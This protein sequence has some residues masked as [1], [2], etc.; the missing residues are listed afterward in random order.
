[1]LKVNP[2]QG[3]ELIGFN[4]MMGMT[5]S[6]NSAGTSQAMSS[7]INVWMELMNNKELL[8]KQ[9]DIYGK[10]PT[11]YNQAVIIVDKNGEISDYALYTLGIKDP[12]EL[13]GLMKDLATGGKI[14]S[15]EQEKYTYDYLMSL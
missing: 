4:D 10:I 8:E 14:E 3:F 13:S 7:N 9:Y 5:S 6:E 1:M 12:A 15:T 2:S 11:K